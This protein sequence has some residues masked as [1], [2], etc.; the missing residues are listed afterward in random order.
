MRKWVVLGVILLVIAGSAYFLLRPRDTV[1][2]HKKMFLTAYREEGWTERLWNRVRG[3]SQGERRLKKHE[4]ALIR[5][6]Y[7]ER[8]QFVVTNISGGEPMEVIGRT[9]SSN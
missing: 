4:D 3:G 9:A 8:K 5:L 7:L 1:E 2:Y 6:G